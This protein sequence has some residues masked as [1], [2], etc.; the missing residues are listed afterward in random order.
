MPQLMNMGSTTVAITTT[1]TRAGPTPATAP[2]PTAVPPA[3]APT[4]AAQ[5][6]VEDHLR[7]ALAAALQCTGLGA[8]PG[9]GGGG[10]GGGGSGGGGGG[11]GGGGQPAPIPPQQLVPIPAAADVC[12]MGTLPQIFKGEREKADTFMNEMLGYLLLNAN[13]PGF[14]SPMQQVALALTLIKGP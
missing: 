9:R 4:G 5:P 12:M 8:P 10:S 1:T 11:G 14:E 6:G 7:N 2:A 13:V 3:A